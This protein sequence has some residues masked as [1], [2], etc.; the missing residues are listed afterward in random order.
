M[1]CNY[2]TDEDGALIIVCSRNGCGPDEMNE[3]KKAMVC[4]RWERCQ[5]C[6][7]YETCQRVLIKRKECESH[8]KL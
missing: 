6:E 3:L 7:S 5:K 4:R 8:Y 2:R 1:T